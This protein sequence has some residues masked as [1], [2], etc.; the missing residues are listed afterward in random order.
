[1]II[2]RTEKIYIQKDEGVIWGGGSQLREYRRR[3]YW[4]LFIPVFTTY[5]IL[6]K[7]K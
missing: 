4:L 6:S 5:E 7:I 1:M 2:R 3:I